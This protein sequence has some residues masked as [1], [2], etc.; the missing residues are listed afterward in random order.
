MYVCL[1]HFL[2]TNQMD[3]WSFKWEGVKRQVSWARKAPK[4]HQW[5]ER[6]EEKE[7]RRRQKGN[8]CTLT[9]YLVTLEIAFGWKENCWTQKNGLFGGNIFKNPAICIY[10]C[11]YVNTSKALR[12]ER[13]NTVVKRNFSLN[14]DIE[15]WFSYPRGQG[16]FTTIK[17]WRKLHQDG[18]N[19]VIPRRR[20]SET[21]QQHALFYWHYLTHKC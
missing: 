3:L 8:G 14:L 5:R 13:Q 15:D 9:C 19:Y 11:M 7:R 18:W 16:H 12:I 21:W 10:V 2:K 1:A 4:S 6:K 17:L 20:R